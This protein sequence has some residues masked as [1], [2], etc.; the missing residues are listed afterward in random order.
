MEDKSRRIREN[1][2]RKCDLV[3]RQ[4]SNK[5]PVM[6]DFNGSFKY[7]FIEITVSRFYFESYDHHFHRMICFCTWKYL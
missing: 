6:L 2:E 3:K 7:Q 4:W 5:S 1:T